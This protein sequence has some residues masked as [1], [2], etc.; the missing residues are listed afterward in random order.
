MDEALVRLETKLI[1]ICKNDGVKYDSD[2]FYFYQTAMIAGFIA[3][4]DVVPPGLG[5]ALMSR[6]PIV[7]KF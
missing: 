6:R 7:N 3:A 4:V 5:I 2:K 1:E